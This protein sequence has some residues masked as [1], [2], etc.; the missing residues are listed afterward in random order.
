MGREGAQRVH[1]D[2][3]SLQGP[4]C[5]TQHS[6]P[7]LPQSHVHLCLAK[8]IHHVVVLFTLAEHRRTSGAVTTRRGW[9]PKLWV[10]QHPVRWV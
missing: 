9:F 6:Q 5:L 3:R 2:T 8:R 1:K 7:L 4:A 10:A